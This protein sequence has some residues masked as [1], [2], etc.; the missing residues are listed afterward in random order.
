MIPQHQGAIDLAEAELKYGHSDEL[1]RLPRKSSLSNSRRFRSCVASLQTPLRSP[2]SIDW[3]DRNSFAGRTCAADDPA[4]LGAHLFRVSRNPVFE[5]ALSSSVELYESQFSG[6]SAQLAYIYLI[7]FERSDASEI[8]SVR[9]GRPCAAARS[10]ETGSNMQ[11]NPVAGTTFR[12]DTRSRLI[13]ATRVR[14]MHQALVP[15]P[16]AYFVA[17]FATDLAYWRT[18]EVMWERFSVWLIAGG[19]VM[20][21]LVALAA[22]IDLVFAKQKPAWFRALGY[23]LAMLL[24]LLNVFVHS[25]DGYT[26]VVPPGLTLSAIVVAILLLSTVPTSWTLTTRRRGARS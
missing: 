10:N 24:S 19:L 23:T 1:R 21:A 11:Y 8:T 6:T 2:L 3:L 17:A 9:P 25:R 15:F 16:V 7:T 14:T 12:P 4:S 20:A 5:H 22:V 13:A 18:V 26:A